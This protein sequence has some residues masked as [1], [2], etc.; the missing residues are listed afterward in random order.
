MNSEK[1]V[2]EIKCVGIDRSFDCIVPRKITGAAL[3]EN[4]FALIKD[5]YGVSFGIYTDSLIVSSRTEKAIVPTLSLDENAIDSGDTL[6][7]I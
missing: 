2:V 7:V 6:Y 1:I 3:C 4:I 5:N